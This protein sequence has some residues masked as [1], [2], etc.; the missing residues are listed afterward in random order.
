MLLRLNVNKVVLANFDFSMQNSII[1]DK[2]VLCQN[3]STELLRC[4]AE[5]K[6]N[7]VG[8]GYKTLAWN[9]SKFQEL[10]YMP[11]PLNIEVLDEWY[12]I[13]HCF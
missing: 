8:S 3:D 6:R 5:S 9:I 1:W 13:Q 2:C 11:L 10:G 7:D 12:G 4:A